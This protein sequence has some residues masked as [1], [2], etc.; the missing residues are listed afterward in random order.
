[1]AEYIL[2]AVVVLAAA[3]LAI[4]FSSF[5]GKRRELPAYTLIIA[6]LV[7]IVSLV[8]NTVSGAYG[9]GGGSSSTSSSGGALS[10]SSPV[11]P[12]GTLLT[13]DALGNLFAIL[14]LFVTL[15]VASSSVT[16]VPP[17]RTSSNPSFYYSLLSFAALGM[18]LISYSADLLMLFVAW[19]LMSIPTYALAGFQKT[20][21]ESNEAAVK[22]AV[23]G[24]LSSAIILY[25]ISLTYGLTGT[26]G[27]AAAATSL[28]SQLSNPLAGIAVLLFIV[29]FGFK[30]SLVPFH[31]W[32]PDAYEGAPT[33]IATL[34]AAGTK[35]AGFVAAIRVVLAI[36][37]VYSL[38]GPQGGIFTIPNVL[39]ILAL[40]TMTLGNLAALTQKS[41]TRLLAYSS[42]AQ[43]G[44]I[45]IGFV[46]YSYAQGN[47]SFGPEGTLGMTGALFHIVNH[48]VMKSTAFLGA[49]LVILK[50]GSGSV[51]SL[52][53]LAK[54][55]PITAFS[56][57]IAF[58]ALAGVPPLSGFWSKLL[59]FTSV[60]NGPYAWLAVAGVLNSAL[61]MGY[62]GW[63]VKR[64]YLDEPEQ[65]EAMHPDVIIAEPVS[66]AF[67]LGVLV[68]LIVA[69][70]IFPGPVI[71]FIH[72]AVP[73]LSGQ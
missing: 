61:S 33:P 5:L 60:L 59:L 4:P 19:E 20:K 36:S 56:L 64:M 10:L 67:I 52:N 54:R 39:A 6:I 24:A 9:V 69:F 30:M 2:F 12:F 44:Y 28:G 11:P 50:L 55:M 71:S 35:K 49:G 15:V 57:A 58:L 16:L 48:S 51:E 38:A 17:S 65:Q 1:M 46:I 18:L 53:G 41:L 42:I 62:Y 72:S 34:F 31:M 45:L 7:A 23:L 68:A 25:A 26:T 13:N 22:Y 47:P 29:G 14:M 3:A 27:I 21:D 63:M 8:L 32:A 70:G 66:F 40:A 43:A 73:G 37:T